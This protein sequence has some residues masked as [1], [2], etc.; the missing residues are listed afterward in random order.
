MS[1]SVAP[2]SD[3]IDGS[4]AFG[5]GFTIEQGSAIFFVLRTG[6]KLK[7]FRGPAFNKPQML[8]NKKL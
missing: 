2:L 7:I 5:D 4:R 1:Y 3:I 8:N 6:L